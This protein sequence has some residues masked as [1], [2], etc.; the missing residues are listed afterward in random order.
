MQKVMYTK[1]DLKKFKRKKNWKR[2]ENMEKRKENVK[3]G[4]RFFEKTK[5]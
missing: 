5:S 4:I 1:K 3:K 2:K